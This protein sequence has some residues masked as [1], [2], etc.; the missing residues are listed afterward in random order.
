MHLS[1][2]TCT[3]KN[4]N[5]NKR[6]KKFITMILT[7]KTAI[8]QKTENKKQRQRKFIMNVKKNCS[9]INNSNTNESYNQFYLNRLALETLY[10]IHENIRIKSNIN[11]ISVFII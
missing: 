6:N 1:K 2:S 7:I 5:K 11:F 10:I 4:K 3:R 8:T 9:R